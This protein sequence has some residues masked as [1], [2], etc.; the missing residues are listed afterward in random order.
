M[1]AR[2]RTSF[3][4]GTPDARRAPRTL[5]LTIALAGPSGTGGVRKAG[6]GVGPS[7]LPLVAAVRDRI[8]RCG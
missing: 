3:V 2:F 5:V 7:E 1:N 8:R 4:R 6:D